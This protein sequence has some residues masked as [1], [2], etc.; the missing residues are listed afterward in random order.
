MYIPKVL[1]KSGPINEPF[2]SQASNM[3]A[4]PGEGGAS[5]GEKKVQNK[6]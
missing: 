3:T 1:K 6:S 4:K 2:V 5:I